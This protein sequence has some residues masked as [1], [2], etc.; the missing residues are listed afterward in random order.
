MCF[1]C[2]KTIGK[3]YHTLST[4]RITTMPGCGPASTEGGT[5][6]GWPTQVATGAI[7]C[8][9]PCWQQQKFEVEIKL[10]CD[11]RH[12][13]LGCRC[14]G[15]HLNHYGKFLHSLFLKKKNIFLILK[16]YIGYVITWKNGK[17]T[18]ES[19]IFLRNTFCDTLN[20]NEVWGKNCDYIFSKSV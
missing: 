14:P 17:V 19:D 11:S 5:Q 12:F 2:L 1:I 7:I 16:K 3:I 8:Y 4:P 13:D 15:I 6:S 18:E 10:T 20:V 9:F